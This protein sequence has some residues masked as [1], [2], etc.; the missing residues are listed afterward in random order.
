MV[1]I[2]NL[3]KTHAIE[4]KIFQEILGQFGPVIGGSDLYRALG[5]PTAGAFR[6]AIRRKSVPIYIFQIPGRRGRF[7]LT[8]DLAFWVFQIRTN[9]D[10]N[11]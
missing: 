10:S 1:A 7:A 9:T 5:Y 6:Q 4:E 3:D 8:R 2:K 11:R